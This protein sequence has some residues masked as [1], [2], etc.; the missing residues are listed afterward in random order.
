MKIKGLVDPRNK[1]FGSV[2]P[3]Q[4]QVFIVYLAECFVTIDKQRKVNRE[5]R[6]L[7]KCETTDYPQILGEDRRWNQ[8]VVRHGV[9]RQNHCHHCHCLFD[10]RLSVSAWTLFFLWVG[11]LTTW[12]QPYV[13]SIDGRLA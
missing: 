13:Y 6:L 1:P 2:L 8:V 12:T 7:P 5:L 3:I 9:R 4:I 11:G 10:H